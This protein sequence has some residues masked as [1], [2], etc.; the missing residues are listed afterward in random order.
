[1]TKVP[2]LFVGQQIFGGYRKSGT[3]DKAG[4][5]HLLTRFGNIQ[6]TKFCY[7]LREKYTVLG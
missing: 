7:Q 5:E 1:M 2:V 4:S 3:N 6:T